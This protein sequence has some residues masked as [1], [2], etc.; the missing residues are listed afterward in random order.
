MKG[1]LGAEMKAFEA[2]YENERAQGLRFNT[3]KGSLE[4]DQMRYREKFGLKPVL[5]CR[6]GFYYEAESRPGRSA[7]H[8]AGAYYIQEPSAMAVVSVLDPK[9][10]ER[11][12]DLCAAPGGKSTHLAD[13]MQGKGLLVSN[14]IHPAHAKLLCAEDVCRVHR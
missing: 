3:R 14:E 8:E 13:R 12:L 11:V 5:W 6:E 9:P 10:G 1:L 4:E 7:L 2:S